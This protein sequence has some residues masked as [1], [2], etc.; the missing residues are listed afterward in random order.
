M[1]SVEW[2]RRFSLARSGE[3]HPNPDAAMADE[4][5]DEIERLWAALR[6]CENTAK[7][8]LKVAKDRGAEIARL[9]SDN[10]K[11]MMWNEELQ[12]KLDAKGLG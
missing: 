9:N 2:L 10:H 12:A 5:A 6:T 11:L 4:A 3:L 7:L 1:D 8:N